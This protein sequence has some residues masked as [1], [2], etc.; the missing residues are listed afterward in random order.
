MSEKLDNI[1]SKCD[2]RNHNGLMTLA[3]Q[4]RE[5]KPVWP[6][7]CGQDVAFLAMVIHERWGDERKPEECKHEQYCSAET[8]FM[9]GKYCADAEAID[10]CPCA[11][12]GKGEKL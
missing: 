12:W 2:N 1:N 7:P 11:A 5:G 10:C 6:S 8:H 3:R 4:I 9:V